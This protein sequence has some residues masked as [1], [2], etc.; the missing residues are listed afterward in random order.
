MQHGF[1]CRFP[2]PIVTKTVN[3]HVEV[4]AGSHYAQVVTFSDQ[5]MSRGEAFGLKMYIKMI[6]L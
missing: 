1:T 2:I 6:N 3:V 5:I 4:R